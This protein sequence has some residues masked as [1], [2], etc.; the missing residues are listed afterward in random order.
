MQPTMGAKIALTCANEG[1][2]DYIARHVQIEAVFNRGLTCA[3]A[4]PQGQRLEL[5]AKGDSKRLKLRFF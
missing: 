4:R 5:D 1:V 3:A 2:L